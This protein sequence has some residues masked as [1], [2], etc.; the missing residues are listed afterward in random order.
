M[1]HWNN[2]RGLTGEKYMLAA[3]GY[4]SQAR[5]LQDLCLKLMK[6]QK[7]IPY[8]RYR[9]CSLKTPLSSVAEWRGN[10]TWNG[11]YSQYRTHSH[12]AHTRQGNAA[13]HRSAL[14]WDDLAHTS[15]KRFSSN[16]KSPR[17]RR[18]FSF[19]GCSGGCIPT[20]HCRVNHWR[21]YPEHDAQP[22]DS[23]DGWRS[24]GL[25][26]G[27]HSEDD[28]FHSAV[29]AL[30]KMNGREDM[31]LKTKPRETKNEILEEIGMTM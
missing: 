30:P 7:I 26:G 18:Q 21:L 24:P 4:A 20:C 2:A 17:K 16:L 13:S 23:A 8:L 27:F 11:G 22:P 3:R 29:T 1:F 19:S 15:E 6:E 5:F 12:A 14:L 28:A 10:L 9:D 25:Q 31:T